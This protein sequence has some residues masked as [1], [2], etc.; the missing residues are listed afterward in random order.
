[1]R[2]RAPKQTRSEATFER[3]VTAAQ[4]LFVLRRTVEVPVREVCEEAGASRSSFYARF[5]DA[6]ALIH[7]CYGRFCE[8]VR[9]HCQELDR[10]WP[11]ARP[12]GDD[13]DTFVAFIVDRHLRFWN[14]QLRLVHAFRAGEALDRT[15]L[16]RRETLDREILDATVATACHHYPDLEPAPLGRA[17]EREMAVIAAAFRGAVDFPDWVAFV[18]DEARQKLVSG[19]SEIVLRSVAGVR[20]SAAEASAPPARARSL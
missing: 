14:E 20:S 16:D 13:F 6:Q 10:D 3:I 15:L 19:L 4:R 8:Q 9:R 1:M 2:H 12:G 5:P 11:G 17:L 18:S 7:V